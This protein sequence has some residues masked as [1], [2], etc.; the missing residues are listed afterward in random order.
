MV[1]VTN[2]TGKTW[3]D[4]HAEMHSEALH[5]IER[6]TIVDANTINYEATL[7]DPKVYTRPW[8]VAFPLKRAEKNFELLEYACHEGNHA[9]E[10]IPRA[11]AVKTQ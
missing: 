3:F 11:R 5:V 1:D 8:K 2:F 4:D 9:L 6:L 7:E 10:N